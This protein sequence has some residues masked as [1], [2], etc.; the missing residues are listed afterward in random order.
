MPG[1]SC[2]FPSRQHPPTAMP[3]ET[4]HKPCGR[5]GTEERHGSR[6]SQSLPPA[7]A[8]LAGAGAKDPWAQRHPHP[9]RSP[10]CTIDKSRGGRRQ[11]RASPTGRDSANEEWPPSWR[12]APGRVPKVVPQ[13]SSGPLPPPQPQV[14]PQA[15]TCRLRLRP[16]ARPAPLEPQLP[17]RGLG[18][19]RCGL[20]ATPGRMLPLAGLCLTH[21][22][23]RSHAGPG[24]PVRRQPPPTAVTRRQVRRPARVGRWECGCPLPP[25]QAAAW[26]RRRRVVLCCSLCCRPEHGA[27]Q[28]CATMARDTSNKASAQEVRLRAAGKQRAPGA[29]GDQRHVGA[30]GPHSADQ[31]RATPAQPPCFMS[32]WPRCTLAGSQI[33][34]GRT[35]RCCRPPASPSCLHAR[36]PF[37]AGGGAAVSCR[38]H[39]L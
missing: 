12:T 33:G 20:G 4:N 23:R 25:R 8:S 18:P 38:L 21:R 13:A 17:P 32:R 6:R 30:K 19:P 35:R 7:A 26:R 10:A 31:L 9:A 14:H 39:G 28:V 2:S 3:Q 11:G 16:C 5:P 36:A 37:A 22:L 27:L 29:G 24:H 15:P 34:R 1:S